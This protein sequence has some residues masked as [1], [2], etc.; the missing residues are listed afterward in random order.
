MNI[1]PFKWVASLENFVEQFI[2]SRFLF[3]SDIVFE[4][5]YS[6]RIDFTTTHMRNC[7]RSCFRETSRTFWE[8]DDESIDHALKD[9]IAVNTPK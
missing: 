5:S 8:G 3:V 1:A 6:F 4:L 2:L 9:G 7:D